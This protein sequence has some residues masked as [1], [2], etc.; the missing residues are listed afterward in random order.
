MESYAD[1]GKWPATSPA[2][3]SSK[4]APM[5]DRKQAQPVARDPPLPRLMKMVGYNLGKPDSFLQLPALRSV[6]AAAACGGDT[7]GLVLFGQE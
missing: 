3:A 5:R 2:V 7:A 4:L 1:L 6:M